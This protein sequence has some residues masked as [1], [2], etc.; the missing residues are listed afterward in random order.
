MKGGVSMSNATYV[1]EGENYNDTLVKGLLQL[2]LTKEEVD[3]ELLEDKKGFMFKKGYVKLKITPKAKDQPSEE[4]DLYEE[5]VEEFVIDK[6]LLQEM[7]GGKSSFQ[8]DYREDGVY[9]RISEKET[10]DLTQEILD[11]IKSKQ[12][13]N[14][15]LVQVS[16]A[17][18]DKSNEYKIAPP[19]PEVLVDS[20]L[21]VQFSKDKMEVSILI[22]KPQGGSLFTLESL[23]QELNN[24]N[25]IYGIDEQQL[26][27]LV[28]VKWTEHFV[29]IAKGKAPING[30]DGRIIYYFNTSQEHKPVIL[31]DGT[32]DFKHLDIV[33]NV[34]KGDLLLEVIPPS[35]GVPGINVLGK[36]VSAKRGKESKF[37]KGKNTTESED[38]LKLYAA[39]DGQVRTD[40]GKIAV[41]EIYQIPGNVD[42]STGN[43]TFNGTVMVNGNVKSGF[44]IV[45]EG[46]IEVNGVVEG[47]TLIAKGDIILNRGIQGN[48]CADL[49]CQGNLVAK[50]IENAKINCQGNIAADFILHSE[51]VAK[52]K[53]TLAGKKSLVVG[54]EVRAGDEI[55]AKIIGS[56]MG[57]LTKIEVGVDPEERNKYE[58]IKG[59]VIELQNNCDN[60]KK[61]ID[62]LSRQAQS[63]QLPQSKEEILIKSVKTHEFLKEKLQ[64]LMEELQLVDEKI[65]N[66]ANGKIHVED[67]IYPGVKVVISNAVRFFYDEAST[68]TLLKKEGEISIGPFE[69]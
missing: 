40:D 54:G 23:R 5:E 60:L 29:T 66:L 55:R 69:K 14:Y 27:R 9:L 34:N 13:K 51:V 38:G 28:K 16:L 26:G 4:I 47:A 7:E 32:V 65:Q 59:E 10:G 57:T 50:Y 24:H 11:Y 15:E 58:K 22:T 3:V 36:E 42:N 8:L 49:Q 18:Q 53:I 19:Q 68:C 30:T 35:E 52:G 12:V 6:D 37:K 1:F 44:K 20:T 46:N 41:S 64:V 21:K 63:A 67:K 56:H 2:N 61:T 43:I 33:K 48:N 45:A 17:T 39:I 31:E 25:I 62:L